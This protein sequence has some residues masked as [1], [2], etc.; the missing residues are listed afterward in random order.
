MQLG[1]LT[2]GVEVAEEELVS[3][4]GQRGQGG[5]AVQAERMW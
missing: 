5:R 4:S 2:E 3:S 1:K